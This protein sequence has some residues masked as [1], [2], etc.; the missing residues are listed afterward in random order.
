MNP[1]DLKTVQACD[2]NLL[3]NLAVLIEEQSVS[4]SAERLDISQPAMSQNLKKLRNLFDDPLFIKHGQGIK[5]TDKARALLPEL[6]EWLQMSSRLILK[7]PFHPSESHGVI[8]VAFMDDLTQNMIPMMLDKITKEAPNVEL[9]FIDKPKD[10]F[11]MLESGELDLAAG[12]T[13][14]PPANIYGRWLNEDQYCAAFA[15]S[16][17]LA[18][19]E[20]PTLEQIFSYQTAEYSSS[21]L[22]EAEVNRLVQDHQLQRKTSFIASSMSVLLHGLM[23]GKH[24]GFIP[25][26]ALE[27]AQWRKKLIGASIAPLPPLESTLYWHARVHRDPLIQWFKDHCLSMADS[28][29]ETGTL[30][31]PDKNY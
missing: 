26:R 15:K 28:L 18:Q 8:R 14:S 30:I 11:S 29:R 9:E 23:A 13:E 27:D 25:Q 4:K 31:K 10:M 6:R 7:E 21:N 19:I 1:A 22:V 5:A 3:L 16:H 2:L 20:S 24:V 17:P 12:G